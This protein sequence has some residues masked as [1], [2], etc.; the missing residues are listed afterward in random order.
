MQGG[1]MAKEI[2][3]IT[4]MPLLDSGNQVLAKANTNLF[5]GKRKCYS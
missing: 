1:R 5:Q 2:V 3:A 4:A